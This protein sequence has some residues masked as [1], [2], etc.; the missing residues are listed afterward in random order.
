MLSEIN[1]KGSNDISSIYGRSIIHFAPDAEE[2]KSL[3]MD[4]PT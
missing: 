2:V 4:K 3:Y 1:T